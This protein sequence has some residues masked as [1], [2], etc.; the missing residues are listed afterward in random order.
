MA[1]K[2]SIQG[3]S[4]RVTNRSQ[5]CPLVT[6]LP[7]SPASLLALTTLK[8]PMSLCMGCWLHIPL[9]KNWSQ[10]VCWVPQW[11][12]H[13]K[14]GK[15]SKLNKALYGLPEVAWVWCEDFKYK[16]KMLGYTPLDRDPG[17]YLKKFLKGIITINMLYC[18]TQLWMGIHR[19]RMGPLTLR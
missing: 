19:I 4:Y 9:W 14:L 15:V 5:T 7:L 3:G 2:I 12:I 1:E 10:P 8:R 16:V 18:I 11:I 6:P 17:V 13:S